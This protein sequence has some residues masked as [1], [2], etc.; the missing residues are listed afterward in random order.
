M[1]Q[2]FHS[3]GITAR[4]IDETGPTQAEPT[5]IPAA[6]ISTTLKGPAFVPITVGTMPDYMTIFGPPQDGSKFGP[7]SAKEWLATQKSFLQLRVLGV[8]DAT[9]RTTS[10]NNAGKVTNAG[11]VVGAQQPQASLSGALGN[12]AYATLSGSAGGFGSPGRTYMLATCMSQSVSSSHFTDAGLGATPVILRGVLFAASG[13]IPALSA[14]NV[15]SVLGAI[16][17]EGAEAGYLQ[18]FHS[19]SVDLTNG[20]QEFVL[21]F[22][23]HKGTARYPRVVTASFDISSANYFPNVL[24]TDPYSMEEAGHLLYSWFDIHPSVGVV[25]GSGYIPALSGAVHSN[26]YENIAFLATSSLNRNVGSATVPNFENF[27]D[28]YRTASSPWVF[29]QNFGGAKEN[30]FKVWLTSDGASEPVKI[31]I[32]NIVPSNTDTYLYGYFDL[33]VRSFGDVDSAKTILEPWRGLS[34]DPK[35]PRYIAKVIG[36]LHTYFNFDASEKRQKLITDG[37][38]PVRSKY[39][40]VEMSENVKNGETNPTA[41]PMGFRGSQHLVTSGSAVFAAMSDAAYLDVSDPLRKMVQPPVPMRLNLAKGLGASQTTDRNLYWGVQFEQINSALETNASTRPNTSL[42]SFVKYYPNFQTIWQNMVVRDNEGVADTA[43]NSILDADRFNNNA[44]SLEKI[45]VVYNATTDLPD[46]GQLQNWSYVRAGNITRDTSALTRGLNITDLLDPSVRQI[47]KFSFFVEGGFNGTLSFN[48]NANE[49]NNSSVTEEMSYPSRG[50]TNGPSVKAYTKALEI[51]SD[52]S[53]VDIQLLAMPGIRHSQLTDLAIRTA[54]N[55]FD[56]LYIMDL[57]VRDINNAVVTSDTQLPSVKNTAA[58]FRNRGL[59]SSFVATY[60]PDG[61]IRDSYNGTVTQVPPSVMVL[62][63]FGINDSVGHPYFAPAGFT[64]GALRTTDSLS[65]SLSRQN[66]DTLASVNINP[67]ASFAGEGIAVW[68]QKTLLARQSSFNRIN[69][70]RLLISI[71]R[72]I[73]KLSN[74]IVFEPNKDSTLEKFRQLVNPVLK[75]VK[76]LNGIENYRVVID[77][78]LT[79]QADIENNTI[80]GE[81]WISPIKSVEFMSLDFVLTN[82]G[83]I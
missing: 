81:I 60:F 7:L 53:E 38:Y 63:A 59:N 5:G 70:R 12:N 39:I 80:R 23:G 35:S 76:T 4:E 10:G 62:G 16:D 73:R 40:R 41:L 48:Q 43:E 78:S 25:T 1:S 33:I 50:Q 8:G 24:N 51:L 3:A 58:S 82:A 46:V 18:G 15:S 9:A 71:R 52:T 49:L 79:T 29:S 22:N 14:T 45:K 31:S 77:D 26:G 83:A 30:L 74:K 2:T 47:A 28:R 6:V 69:V 44:F 66:M 55:R 20:K 61:N 67:I 13:V 54:E 11:F 37:D 32:E 17:T 19:G 36:D 65:V 75:N 72:Q 56:A 42:A 64:R 27:E 34:L 68:G 57:E 21:L